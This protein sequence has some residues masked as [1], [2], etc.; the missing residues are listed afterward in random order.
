MA[1][2]G[3]DTIGGLFL[4]MR[5]PLQS[6]RCTSDPLDALPPAGTKRWSAGRK[7]AVVRAVREGL[8]DLTEA[9]ER[10]TLS[11]EELQSWDEALHQ[12]GVAGL[13]MK[14]RTARRRRSE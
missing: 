14:S 11:P 3:E 1:E 8:L 2:V 7:A 4:R 9:C 10:Y 12:K 5:K 6:D 13:L